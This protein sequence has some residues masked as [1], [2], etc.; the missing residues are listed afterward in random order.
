M[1][2]FVHYLYLI[3]LSLSAIFSLKTF[4]SQWAKRFRLF[5]VFL[6]A[7]FFVELFAI[8]WKLVLHQ[9]AYW[10][11][12]KSNL[13]IYNIYLVPQYLFYFTFFSLEVQS[14]WLKN[15]RRPLSIIY[16]LFGLA[17]MAFIQGM[18]QLNTYS[19]IAG[20]ALV[21]LGSVSYFS[22][23]LNRPEPSPVTTYP[24]FWIAAGSFIF[25]TVSLPYFISINYLSRTNL[26]MAITLFNIL[27]V[28]NVIMYLFYLIAFLCNN[29]Y[30]KRPL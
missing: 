12:S 27:L 21:L 15:V 10:D 8:S 18:S 5:S 29:P 11:Y 9:T 16:G 24:T 3:P 20:S 7:T 25:H 6:M 28:L 2:N 1:P 23:E 17:N 22:K 13:W 4:K 14:I 30:H 26:A 19:I